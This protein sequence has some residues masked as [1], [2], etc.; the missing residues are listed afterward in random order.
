MLPAML[1]LLREELRAAPAIRIEEKPTA[2]VPS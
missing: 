1:L 2:D